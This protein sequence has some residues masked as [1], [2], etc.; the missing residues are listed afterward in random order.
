M[1]A[2]QPLCAASSS[3]PPALQGGCVPGV[4]AGAVLAL[5]QP[6]QLRAS[7]EPGLGCLQAF[8][9]YLLGHLFIFPCENAEAVVNK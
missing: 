1:P 4:A 2:W 5:R 7:P 6:G 9:Y 8:I 3:S